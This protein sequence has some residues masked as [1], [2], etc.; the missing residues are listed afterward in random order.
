MEC[1]WIN[2]KDN[3]WKALS[4][5]MAFLLALVMYGC[6]G[7]SSDEPE[8]DML[9]LNATSLLIEADGADVTEFTV[10]KGNQDVTA[11]AE[12]LQ[13]GKVFSGTRFYTD[14]EGEYKFSARYN[15]ETSAEIV[16]RATKSDNLVM[17]ADPD[18]ERYE[19][20]VKHVLFLQATG[21]WCG[22]CPLVMSG[23]KTYGETYSDGL[24]VFAAA[25]ASSSIKDLMETNASL[26]VLNWLGISSFPTLNVN[27]IP[28]ETV[29]Y[30][31]DGNVGEQNAGMIREVVEQYKAQDAKS[32]IAAVVRADKASSTVSV[33]AKIKIAESGSYRVAAWLLE[34][35]I[36]DNSQQ[37]YTD[38]TDDFSTHNNVLRQSS[39]SLAFGDKLGDSLPAGSTK[40]FTCSFTLSS[41]KM[42][43][44]R[45]LIMVTAPEGGVF[46]VDNVVACPL[47][48][49][50]GFEYK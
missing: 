22:W 19:G 31:S 26:M 39:A 25:H 1:K 45:V 28:G 29:S 47:N 8:S 33:E 17:P 6:S 2:W 27:L 20:F 4:S 23:I 30:T 40:D 46:A 32:A 3:G 35:G 11:A 42:D 38:L 34:D 50:V 9:V 36:S 48:S 15:G 41:E 7:N 37:N 16:V 14:T 43:N 13:D 44:C 21:T 49:K 24:A 18:P 5:V 10:T 12:I